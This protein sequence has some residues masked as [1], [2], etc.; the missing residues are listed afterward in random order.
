MGTLSL[1]RSS[2]AISSEM[3]ATRQQD[4][5]KADVLLTVRDL[6]NASLAFPVNRSSP[7]TA[8]PR[9]DKLQSQFIS[10]GQPH[11]PTLELWHGKVGDPLLVQA[12][13]P[14]NRNVRLGLGLFEPFIVI[15]LDFDER[16]KDILILIRVLVPAFRP[17]TRPKPR[18]VPLTS[19]KS[20]AT[21]PRPQRAPH[22]PAWHPDSPA[23]SPRAY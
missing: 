5:R 14:S 18:K 12:D 2:R 19:A 3:S 13:V 23:T 8:H 4:S 7:E 22:P 6:D 21:P 16:S 20:A 15:C 1:R 17:S 11:F 9:P 10:D